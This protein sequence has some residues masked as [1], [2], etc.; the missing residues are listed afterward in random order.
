MTSNSFGKVALY[1]RSG[2]IVLGHSSDFIVTD[3]EMTKLFKSFGYPF[4]LP[5]IFL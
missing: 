2:D 5:A 3:S 1:L 4:E